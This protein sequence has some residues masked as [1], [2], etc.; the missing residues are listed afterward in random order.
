M[1]NDLKIPK[2]TL[3]DDFDAVYPLMISVGDGS[4]ILKKDSYRDWPIFREIRKEKEFADTF[5]MI[6]NEE[7]VESNMTIKVEAV[8]NATNEKDIVSD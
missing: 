4:E 6:F 8:D 1:N 7:L 2:L 3:E 5:K